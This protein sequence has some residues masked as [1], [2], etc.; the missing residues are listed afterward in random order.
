M[1]FMYNAYIIPG[2]QFK[3]LSG[4]CSLLTKIES[5][6]RVKVY[7]ED[8]NEPHS[9]TVHFVVTP[10]EKSWIEVGHAL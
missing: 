3:I 1:L 4:S 7:Y 10:D 5:S 6:F 8:S 9:T 2:F